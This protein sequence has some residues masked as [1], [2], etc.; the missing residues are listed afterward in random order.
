V[1]AG[2]QYGAIRYWD[3]ASGQELACYK[4]HAGMIR[5]VAFAPDGRR[6]LSS[7]DD[8]TVRLWGLPK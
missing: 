5:S 6:A 7:G 2:D 1:I 8:K 3:A 4:G